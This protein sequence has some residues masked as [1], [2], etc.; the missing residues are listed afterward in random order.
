VIGVLGGIASGKSRAGRLLA[1]PAGRVLDADAI[2]RELQAGPEF[3]AWARA[4]FGPAVLQPSGALDRAALAQRV[5][6]EPEARKRL[7]DWI[8]PAV[9]ARIEQALSEARAAGVPRVVL[10]VP[11]LLENDRAHGLARACDLLVFVEV[12]A[13]ERERRALRDRGWP[14]GEVAKREASQWPLDE[15]R[16][17]AHH[18]LRN[19]GSEEDLAAAV[20]ELLQELD[21]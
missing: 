1:G 5:F 15:K 2:V 10:D 9:R 8:H 18:V 12:D 11:L 6:G 16:A 13:D 21:A 14:A 17:R 19:D 3:L 4:T 7:E 20:G